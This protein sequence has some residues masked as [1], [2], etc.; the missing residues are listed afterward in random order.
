MRP[1]FS[2]CW[3]AEAA[4]SATRLTLPSGRVINLISAPAFLASKFE[5]F[6]ARQGRALLAASQFRM[7]CGVVEE[8]IAMV[9]EVNTY[10]VG[11][12]CMS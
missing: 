6:A 1:G 12:G 10:L 4:A 7:W 9:E 8:A 3:Y 2:N 5:A 11:T